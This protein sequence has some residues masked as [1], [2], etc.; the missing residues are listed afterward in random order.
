MKITAAANMGQDFNLNADEFY[1]GYI[2]N[3][4]TKKY[5]IIA[6]PNRR[7]F[8]ESNI[9][10]LSE[11]NKEKTIFVTFNAPYYDDDQKKLI[12]QDAKKLAGLG[13][14]GFIVSDFLMIKPLKKLTNLQ[15]HMSTIAN[16]FNHKTAKMY[17]N[18]GADR[19]ILPRQLTLK[20]IKQIIKNTPGKYEVFML[21]DMC[22]NIDGFCGF[23]HGLE[24]I[25]GSEHGCLLLNKFK[26]SG[27]PNPTKRIINKRL[28]KTKFGRFCGA[29]FI[30]EFKK[31]GIESVKIVGRRMP[32]EE[33]QKA[34]N[35]IRS[36]IDGNHPQKEYAKAF[37]S[38]CP[39][40]CN[41]YG[42]TFE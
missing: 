29:C 5:G 34:I 27:S 1:L 36:V 10:D 42:D 18:M 2:S 9:P 11:I 33:K 28:E 7:Y 4:W 37:N 21:N 30:N 25:A 6:S 23:H 20:E 22:K 31:I 3:K 26:V 17:F 12:I 38:R 14:N 32:F 15:I 40:L 35:F 41:Y 19:I 8:L 13:I 39:V 16:T 24:D